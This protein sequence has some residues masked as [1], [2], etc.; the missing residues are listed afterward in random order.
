MNEWDLFRLSSTDDIFTFSLPTVR[1]HRGNL[2]YLQW[3]DLPFAF[4]RV[5][6]LFDIPTGARRGGHAHIRQQ[7]ILIALSGSFDVVVDDGR[8]KSVFSL[9]NPDKGLYI[10]QGIWREIENFSANSICL[11]LNNEEYIEA[12]YIRD[13]AEFLKKKSGPYPP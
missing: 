10:P 11:V 7:E 12:D 6:Y 2:V 4:K 8:Q 9:N 3:S 1:D 13:Y 5:Y